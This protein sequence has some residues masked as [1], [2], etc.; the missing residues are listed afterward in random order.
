MFP[1]GFVNL[2]L[3]FLFTSLLSEQAT[4]GNELS[5]TWLFQFDRGGC[6]ICTGSQPP[7]LSTIHFSMHVI[8]VSCV[9]NR[10]SNVNVTYSIYI[11]SFSNIHWSRGKKKAAPVIPVLICICRLLRSINVYEAKAGVILVHLSSWNTHV[12]VD[13]H[14]ETYRHKGTHNFFH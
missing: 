2:S 9:G 8:D 12:Q 6:K 4:T 14:K 13:I 3:Y 5:I 10:I 7:T 11:H 1:T